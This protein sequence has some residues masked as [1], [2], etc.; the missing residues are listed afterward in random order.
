MKKL[1]HKVIFIMTI[2]GVVDAM[3]S[4]SS[5][6]RTVQITNNSLDGVSLELYDANNN[7]VKT[8]MGPLFFSAGK[9]FPVQN[10]YC[11]QQM[12]PSLPNESVAD[13]R[14]RQS[15]VPCENTLLVTSIKFTFQ[16]SR[17]SF[18]VPMPTSPMNILPNDQLVT[19][20]NNSTDQIKAFF[21]DKDHK[22]LNPDGCW[23]TYADFMQAGGPINRVYITKNVATITIDLGSGLT[24]SMPRP[25][26]KISNIFSNDQHDEIVKVTNNSEN[27]VNATL[28]NGNIIQFTS[29]GQSHYIPKIVGRLSI[30]KSLGD[31]TWSPAQN[32]VMQEADFNLFV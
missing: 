28:P 6:I 24:F 18:T 13:F 20:I 11:V 26:A 22:L 15:Q 14:I 12:I 25:T 19:L 10:Y 32:I 1:L 9:S 29:P 8:G 27:F 7:F 16:H 2:F 30:A 5:T 3:A 4:N 17:L 31:G 21:Y 23:L